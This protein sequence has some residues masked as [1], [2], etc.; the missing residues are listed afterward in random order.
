MAFL[1]ACRNLPYHQLTIKLRRKKH[2]EEK[3]LECCSADPG[4]DVIGDG[5]WL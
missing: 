1:S 5:G 4:F 2:D 3:V